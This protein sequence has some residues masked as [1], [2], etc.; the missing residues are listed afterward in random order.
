MQRNGAVA[1]AAGG[2]RKERTQRE[3]V[4][5]ETA[6]VTRAQQSRRVIQL[7]AAEREC[8]N[9]RVDRV[10]RER[11]PNR[12]LRLL[13]LRNGLERGDD[14]F[15]A[16]DIERATR[17]VIRKARGTGRERARVTERDRRGRDGLRDA[18]GVDHS[19]GARVVAFA[20]RI[21]NQ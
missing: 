4:G 9:D 5:G 13:P 14:R 3:S 6:R 1:V 16:L 12:L 21:G 7:R 2:G 20:G 8:E 10:D 18:V 19:F 11:R 17:H 15:S